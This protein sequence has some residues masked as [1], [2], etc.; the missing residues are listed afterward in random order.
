MTMVNH[1]HCVFF[2]KYQIFFATENYKQIY[3][4]MN[5]HL[6]M[7]RLF[8]RNKHFDVVGMSTGVK[9]MVL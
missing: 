8:G 7:E 9:N 5:K 6:V 4:L 3:C 2:H 1:D